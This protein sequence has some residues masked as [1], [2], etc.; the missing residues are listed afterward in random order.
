MATKNTSARLKEIFSE[1]SI[2]DDPPSLHKYA[3]SISGSTVTPLCIVFPTTIDHVV[4]LVK[5]ATL[6][7]VQL[8]PISRGKNFGYGEAQGSSEGQVVVDLSRMNKIIKVD[9]Q[10][11]FASIEP[12]VSQ[13]QMY[14]H[15]KSNGI[16]LQLDVTGAGLDASITGNILERGF[17]HTD[18]GDRWSRVIN[19]TVVTPGGEVIRTG[20]SAFENANASDVY[21]YGIGPTI[22]GLFSQSNFGIVVQMTLELKPIAEVTEM[23]VFST[24][25]QDAAGSLAEA[26]RILKLNGIVNSAIHIANRSRA[27][28]QKSNKFVGAWNMSGSITGSPGIVRAKRKVVKKIFRKYASRYRLEFLGSRSMSII[29]WV[30]KNII[31]IPVYEPLQDAFDLVNGVPT[32]NPLQVLLNDYKLTSKN[33]DTANYNI[34]FSWINAVCK[35]EKNSITDLLSIIEPLFKQFNYEFRVTFTAVNP[36]TLIMI[37]NITYD[38]ND[39]EIA[40]ATS[41]LKNCN[42]LLEE[43]GFLPY[44]AG[45]GMYAKLPKHGQAYTKLIQQIKSA[46]D[47][48][49]ILAPGKYNI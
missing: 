25:N 47:P 16:P 45:S 37:S 24:K 3:S 7:K 36:R 35:A 28:G 44:R 6:L 9:Q 33:L 31:T 15:L 13:Q 23:F 40:K 22:D 27:V 8:F 29:R 17:G 12:G 4:Q 41:F 1:V 18:Y 32:D 42:S 39:T 14:S 26:V 2:V 46:I 19:L 49:G 43:K 20:M 34:C 10:M 30:N 11:A 21:S 5:E 48:K 38:R